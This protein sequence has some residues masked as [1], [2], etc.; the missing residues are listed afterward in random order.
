[1]N[2]PFFVR[3]LQQVKLVI[4][5]LHQLTPVVILMV[6]SR[7]QELLAEQ[8]WSNIFPRA[9]TLSIH[10]QLNSLPHA[11]PVEIELLVNLRFRQLNRFFTLNQATADVVYQFCKRLLRFKLSAVLNHEFLMGV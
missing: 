3:H 6:L 11:L 10:R 5:L 4:S 9:F 1:M 2:L 8:L 7:T